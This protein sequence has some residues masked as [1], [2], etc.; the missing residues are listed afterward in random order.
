MCLDSCWQARKGMFEMFVSREQDIRASY[1]SSSARLYPRCQYTSSE[2]LVRRWN[3]FGKPPPP[4]TPSTHQNK[5]GIGVTG[6]LCGGE[7]EARISISLSCS[8]F[9]FVSQHFLSFF[10]WTNERRLCDCENVNASPPS[11]VTAALSPCLRVWPLRKTYKH[12]CVVWSSSVR[13]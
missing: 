2:Q 3:S 11:L 8:F 10:L 4:L 12:F 6:Q 13:A 7:K 1:A 5:G 9:P